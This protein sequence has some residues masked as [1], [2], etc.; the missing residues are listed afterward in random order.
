MAG[1]PE[2]FYI[3]KTIDTTVTS[4]GATFT[5][6]EDNTDSWY[7]TQALADAAA[8]DAGPDFRANQGAV[9]VPNGWETG[10][11]RN[12]LDGT[13]RQLAVSDLDELGQRKAAARAL[14]GAL[15]AWEGRSRGSAARET[16]PGRA[17]QQRT[18]SVSDTGR[19]TSS[20]RT[21]T[22]VGMRRNRSRGLTR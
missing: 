12:P 16:D 20:S 2:L 22:G 13:W 11:I 8:V 17:S 3:S 6:S 15:L 18:S 14:H 7:A 5:V 19:P 21:R 9:A 4:G 10:W 1:E